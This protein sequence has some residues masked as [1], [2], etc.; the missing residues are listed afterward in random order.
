VRRAASGAVRRAAA[1]PASPRPAA[2]R[3]APKPVGGSKRAAELAERVAE[4]GRALDRERYFDVRRMLTP[5][6]KEAPE[7]ASAHE[8]LGLAHYRLGAWRQAV[9]SLEAH[10][11][12]AGGV[13]HVPVLMDSYRALRR[14]AAIE[15]LWEELREASPSAAL[16]AE[17][18]IVVA[19]ALADRGR[20]DDAI[21]VLRPG[22]RSPTR[23]RE[24]HLRMWYALADLF[25]RNGEP[26]K[27]RSLFSRIRSVDPGF[28]DVEE[29][30][31]NLGA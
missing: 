27:A 3:P 20:F 5:I 18:R 9:G 15:P 19:G 24:H 30:L 25:D 29:R 4:A 8:I 26:I 12:L 11:A 16:V 22:E 10:R 6:V 21:E 28:A 1:E 23:V 17:G 2:P 31:A 7:L 14:Y 13:E